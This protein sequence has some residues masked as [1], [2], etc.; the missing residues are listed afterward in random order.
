MGKF[1][2]SI[3]SHA[4]PLQQVVQKESPISSVASQNKSCRLVP[5]WGW[6]ALLVGLF[7]ISFF[8]FFV[9]GKRF[10]YV[11]HLINNAFRMTEIHY[12]SWWYWPVFWIIVIGTVVRYFLVRRVTTK[13]QNEHRNH[14]TQLQ[15]LLTIIVFGLMFILICVHSD[16]AG[17][18]KSLIGK[19]HGIKYPWWCLPLGCGLLIAAVLGGILRFQ[20]YRENKEEEESNIKIVLWRSVGVVFG[21]ALLVGGVLA[22]R[23]GYFSFSSVPWWGWPTLWVAV[24]VGL[25]F[26]KVIQAFRE[27][28]TSVPMVSKPAKSAIQQPTAATSKGFNT[29][30][31]GNSNKTR[32]RA[33]VP[34]ERTPLLD[35][36]NL[37]ALREIGMIV[38]LIPVGLILVAAAGYLCYHLITMERIDA[39]GYP[40]ATPWWVWILPFVFLGL[41]ILT[42]KIVLL[43]RESRE[44]RSFRSSSVIPQHSLKQQQPKGFNMQGQSGFRQGQRESVGLFSKSAIWIAIGAGAI[45]LIILIIVVFLN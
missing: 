22:Y 16:M 18:L 23:N 41:G 32:F 27:S 37:S 6:I 9:V 44:N 5:K 4:R 45:L 40:V 25:L 20:K 34:A 35:R 21:I 13:E 31:K 24:I 11:S 42:W 38:W 19:F 43:I 7:I 1:Q 14:L 28:G 36:L 26:Y 39:E 10:E 29:S 17:I 33:G 12:R 2:P 30:L 3:G 15:R 8:V